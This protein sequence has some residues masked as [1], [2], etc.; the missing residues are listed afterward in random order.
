M[1][2]HI[3]VGTVLAMAALLTSAGQN[4]ALACTKTAGCVMD[5]FHD[6][7]AMKR[8]GRMEE[9]IKAGRANV[10]AFRALQAAEKAYYA[11]RR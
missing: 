10:E 5:V 1:I 7:Y 4:N 11:R 6:D 3:V 2:N 9:A 8:D